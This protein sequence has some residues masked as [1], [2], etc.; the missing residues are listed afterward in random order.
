V[1][2]GVYGRGVS[3]LPLNAKIFAFT[4]T[5][6][7]AVSASSTVTISHIARI[8][9]TGPVDRSRSPLVAKLAYLLDMRVDDLITGLAPAATRWRRSISTAIRVADEVEK[10]RLEDP[11][12]APSP[13]QAADVAA[14]SPTWIR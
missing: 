8:C 5:E 6:H 12:F 13:C 4:Q 10:R 1:R 2:E 14:L 9:W 7:S 11:E 3:P